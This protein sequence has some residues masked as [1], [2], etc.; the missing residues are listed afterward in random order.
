MTHLIKPNLIY[1]FVALTHDNHLE[2]M[3]N[4]LIT[5]VLLIFLIQYLFTLMK[6]TQ[7]MFGQLAY[8]PEL[9]I[10]VIKK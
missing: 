5:F 7:W 6:P 2:Q 4:L 1:Y 9:L 3:Y 8:Q 10:T